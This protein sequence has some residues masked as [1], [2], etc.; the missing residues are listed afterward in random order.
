MVIIDNLSSHK[1]DKA[2]LAIEA[3]GA[4][5]VFLPPYSPGLN[6]I[7]M[8]FSKLET[9]LRKAA[10]RTRDDL[11][12]RIGQVVDAFT[13]HECANYLVNQVSTLISRERDCACRHHCPRFI[14]L[15]RTCYQHL[16]WEQALFSRSLSS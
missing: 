1:S 8:A 9:L 16:V 6:P 15:S 10:E 11:R 5:L 4:E 14:R 12:Y 13:P 3:S 7:E 2:R